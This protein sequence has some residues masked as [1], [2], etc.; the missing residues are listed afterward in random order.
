[1][2]PIL[3]ILGA[4]GVGKSA[5]AVEIAQKMGVNYVISADSMQIYKDM[6]VGTAKITPDEAK[7]IKHHLIDVVNPDQS[8]SAFDF[9]QQAQQVI[10]ANSNQTNIIVGGTGLYF[11]S[12][13]HGLDFESS[14]K[15][16]K[17]RQDMQELL[18]NQGVQAV[19]DVL[20]GLDGQVYDQIDK[21]NVKR[22]IRAI[23]I[24]STGGNLQDKPS[25]RKDLYPHVLFV[26]YRDR[27]AAYQKINDRVD[28]MVQ[29]GLLQE[30][31]SLYKRYPNRNLQSF[32]AI[33]YKEV[34]G[35]LDG[36]CTF[37]QAVEQ[38]KINTRHYAK[39]QNTYFK[40][41][42]NTVWVN[43]DGKTIDQ[44]ANE[45]LAIYQNYDKN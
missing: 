38:I 19:L 31:E 11:D 5:V 16:Q 34:L 15:T 6:D 37:A 40:R 23:E 35:H 24:L 27:E 18:Q 9:A 28:K 29:Q 26:L 13:L 17:I 22:V 1:M 36:I 32:K 44:I 3:G 45:V 10:D 2:K 30:V 8:F 41:M 39:R 21:N 20:K 33:G 25:K 12:L 7:G 14:D 42:Q 43:V 4:T